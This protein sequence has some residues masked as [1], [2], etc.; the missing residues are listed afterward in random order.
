MPNFIIQDNSIQYAGKTLPRDKVPYVVP[1][2][3]LTNNPS[4]IVLGGMYLPA[5]TETYVNG[6]KIIAADNILDGPPV[7]ERITG[8]PIEIEFEGTIRDRQ[9][10]EAGTPGKWIFPQD[11]INQIWNNI[12]APNSVLKVINTNLNGIGIRELVIKNINY[13][14][15]K[16]S[17][18]VPFRLRCYENVPG[19][20]LII[21]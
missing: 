17:V 15:V 8:Q 10:S 1:S 3:D 13:N 16:G 11:V 12:W 5:D 6:E 19:S 18:N 9:Y 20:S 2:A 21:K 14:T 7:T 4:S